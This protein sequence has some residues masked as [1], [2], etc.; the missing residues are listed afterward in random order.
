[1]ITLIANSAGRFKQAQ[2][3]SS[4]DYKCA[5]GRSGMVAAALKREGDGASPVGMWPLRRVFYRADRL[6]RPGTGLSCLPIGTDQGWCDDPEH[7]AYNQLVTLPFSA[8]HEVMWREDGVYDVVVELGHNDDPPV[9]GLGSAIFLHVARPD[10]SPTEGCIALAL[11]D[12]LCVL[13]TC[14]SNSVLEICT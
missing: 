6:A 7:A 12:F 2:N 1:M 14:D 13:Q 4:R 8:S 9:P 5:I 10:Y 3:G 11:E